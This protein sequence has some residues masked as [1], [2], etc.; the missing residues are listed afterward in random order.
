MN[1]LITGGSGYLG[2][3][4]IP[5]ACEI[6][7][8]VYATYN[9]MPIISKNSHEV[10]IDLTNREAVLQ[11]VTELAPSAIIHTAAINP[12]GD[13]NAMMLVNH[14]GTAYVAE[15]ASRIGA[16]LVHVSSDVVHDGRN[17]P[18]ADDDEPNPLNL[19]GKSKAAGEVAVR[20]ACPSAAI[21]R[22][23]LIYGLETIDRGTAGFIQRLERGEKLMLFNDVLRQPIWVESLVKALLKLVEIND[24]AGILNVA[25]EQIL[26]REEFGRLMLQWWQADYQEQTSSGRAADI[27]SHIPLDLRL[28]IDKAKKLLQMSFPGVDDLVKRDD[29]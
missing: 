27:S 26:T 14:L 22:T 16:R 7:D 15:A 9:T 6:F 12:G 1:I 10:Q 4:L 13:D 23:S 17:A 3:H 19:Y 18:Y 25:G 21:V 11:L 29:F 20:R 2:Q 28:S 8:E 24:F 5:K